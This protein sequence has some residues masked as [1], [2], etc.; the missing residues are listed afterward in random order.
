[1]RKAAKDH[2]TKKLIEGP[3]AAGNT[4]VVIDDVI[5]TGGS[6]LQ[7][8]AAVEAEGGKV[9]FCHRV[10]GPTGGRPCKH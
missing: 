4:V 5:T 1:M 6:T 10:G 9:A 8:I 7:A 2:G 3:F